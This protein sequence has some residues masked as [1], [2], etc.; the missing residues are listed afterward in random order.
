MV[1]VG[2]AVPGIGFLGRFSGKFVVVFRKQ[3]DL[4]APF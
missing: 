1:M 2:V 4:A 3:T